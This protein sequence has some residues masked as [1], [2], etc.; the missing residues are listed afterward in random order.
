ML[1]LETDAAL[2]AAESMLDEYI[3]MLERSKGRIA[4]VIKAVAAG[5]EEGGVLVH[6][7]GGKDRTGII[8]ALLLSLAGVPRDM[9]V[10]DYAVSEARL[11]HTYVAWLEEQARKQSG[12]VERPR[13]MHSRPETLEG[14]LD[15][16]D[17]EYGGAEG[18]LEAAGVTRDEMARVREH[19]VAVDGA[20]RRGRG[21]PCNPV[22][23]FARHRV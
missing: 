2:D 15:Y 16:L 4:E 5:L 20:K 23:G 3:I 9:I 14:L 21:V 22:G 7:H 8:V 6:C 12:V 1:D 13:W 10:E 11:E 17:R 18:Y 19:L